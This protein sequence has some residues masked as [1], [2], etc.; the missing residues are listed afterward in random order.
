MKNFFL[1]ALALLFTIGLTA[2]DYVQFETIYLKPDTKHLSTLTKNMK[3]HNDKYHSADPHHANV[4]QVSN[5]PRSGWL[6]WSMGPTTFADLDKRPAEGGHDEDWENNVMPYILEMGEIEYW[7]LNPDV[8][9]DADPQPNLKLRFYKVNNE[10]GFL[11]NDILE[12]MSKVRAE[13]PEGRSWGLYNNMLQQGNRG[14]HIASVIG[15]ANMGELDKGMNLD[16]G[17]GGSF[18]PT[19]E[20]IYG[21]GAWQP[22]NNALQNAFENSYDE[23]WS[24]R[25]DMSAPP[26][27]D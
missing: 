11:V 2:Q 25:T 27:Q 4:W 7:R 20:K 10:M 9:V 8:S 19:F 22:F 15:F 17:W 5:G 26:I 21:A 16:P 14:R 23:I 6:V 12:K 24:L 13:M 1:T 3:A 18:R